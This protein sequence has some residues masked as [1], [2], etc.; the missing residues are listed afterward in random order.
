MVPQREGRVSLNHSQPVRL[1]AR[2]GEG[3]RGDRIGNWA[4]LWNLCRPP[5]AEEAALW[6][7]GR[8]FSAPYKEEFCKAELLRE[9]TG[10]SQSE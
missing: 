3:W 10:R 8:Q 9:G 4:L 7:T 6:G 1:A 2:D 5:R